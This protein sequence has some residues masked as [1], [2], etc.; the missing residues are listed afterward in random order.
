MPRKVIERA[1]L[2]TIKG[3]CWTC[4]K[5]GVLDAT[6]CSCKP[7]LAW[8]TAKHKKGLLMTV[9]EAKTVLRKAPAA[10]VRGSA[11][12]ARDSRGVWL[13][14]V[15]IAGAALVAYGVSW[16]SVPAALVLGGLVLVAALETR[17]TSTPRIPA[18]RPPEEALRA[19]ARDAAIVI[20]T[21]RFGLGSVDQRYVDKLSVTECEKLIQIARG[22]TGVNKT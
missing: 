21:E 5:F 20:N 18:V 17:G 13:L 4:G 19:T 22:I 1:A 2:S 7:C 9:I 15:E 12:F 16:W 3:Y 14:L 10:L 11:R 8:W 6:S